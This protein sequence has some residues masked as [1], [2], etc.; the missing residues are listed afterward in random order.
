LVLDR[1]NEVEFMHMLHYL[2]RCHQEA[3]DAHYDDI[4][5][6]VTTLMHVVTDRMMSEHGW[7]I[8]EK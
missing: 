5:V 3:M 1:R 4:A 7:V 2:S 8:I 6:K